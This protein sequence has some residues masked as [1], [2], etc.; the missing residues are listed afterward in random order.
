MKKIQ[1]HNYSSDETLYEAEVF[2][3]DY[4]ELEKILSLLKKLRTCYEYHSRKEVIVEIENILLD[5]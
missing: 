3:M 5:I 1:Q 2:F 4:K